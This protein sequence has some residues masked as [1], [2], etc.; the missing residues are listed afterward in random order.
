MFPKKL[1]GLIP[2]GWQDRGEVG[3]TPHETNKEWEVFTSHTFCR[4]RAHIGIETTGKERTSFMFCP[5][6]LI[7]LGV[8][9]K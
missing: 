6:C 2:D 9:G 7:K 3:A 1:L 5:K 8:K 4:T